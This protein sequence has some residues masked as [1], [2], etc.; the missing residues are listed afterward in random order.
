VFEF[1]GPG[2]T[3]HLAAEV[4]EAVGEIVVDGLGVELLCEA[5]DEPLGDG[6]V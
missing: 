2:V 3:G 6:D 1:Q 4:A 5:L